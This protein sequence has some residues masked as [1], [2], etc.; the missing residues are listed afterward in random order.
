MPASSSEQSSSASSS[1]SKIILKASLALLAVCSVSIALSSN[2]SNF[3]S[4]LT[5][6]DVLR[7]STSESGSSTTT[8][9]TNRVVVRTGSELH[10]TKCGQEWSEYLESLPSPDDSTDDEPPLIQWTVSGG[11]EY[12]AHADMILTKWSSLGMDPVLVI[13]LDQETADTVC[14]HHHHAVLWSSPKRSYSRVADAK[15][16]VAGALADRGY[17]GFFMEMDVFCHSNP[18]PVFLDYMNNNHNHKKAYDLVNIG[19]GHM[20]WKINIGA[21][22]ASTRMGP[23]FEGLND[24]LKHSLHQEEY[25]NAF[26]SSRSF[27]D[28]DTYEVCLPL[29][30]R[31]DNDDDWGFIQE[32]LY[33]LEDGAHQHDIAKP[34]RSFSNFTHTVV[35]H[36]LMQSLEPPTVY[37]STVCIH[38][39]M[40]QPFTPLSFKLGVAKFLGFDPAI[41]KDDE[42]L[43]KLQA[44]DFEYGR[45]FAKAIWEG[46]TKMNSPDLFKGSVQWELS[47]MVEIALRTN[48]TLV[49]PKYIRSKEAWAI[50]TH[51][52]LDI[53]SL[54]VPYRILQRH[55]AAAALYDDTTTV[56]IGAKTLDETMQRVLNTTDSSA[57]VLAIDK[58]CHIQDWENQVLQSRFESLKWCQDLQDLKWVQGDG[59][60]MRFCQA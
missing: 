59:G 53:R 23:F 32:D 19:H 47:L 17:R 39:L 48:R 31:N 2:L 16:T 26:N 56:I 4:S 33:E 9:S 7:K 30:S 46:E 25:M 36:H 43:L 14:A 8:T 55:E 37:D 13:A 24:F 45:C 22:L 27:F 12:R 52:I 42:R 20:G 44:G 58:I 34:C 29:E 6:T 3:T 15:F 60:W 18:V 57:K 5:S 38:P 49:L 51:A 41:L 40:G 10:L 50:P 1:S 21:Y 11:E 35:P 54:P 28:Q